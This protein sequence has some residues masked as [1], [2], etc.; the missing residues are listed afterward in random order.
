LQ[1]QQSFKRAKSASYCSCSK[2]GLCKPS[3]HLAQ[4]S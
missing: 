3:E 2:R 1:L 4:R